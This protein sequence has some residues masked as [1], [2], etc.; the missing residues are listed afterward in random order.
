MKYHPNLSTA[1][2]DLAVSSIIDTVTTYNGKFI[3][4]IEGGIPTSIDG[5]YCIIADRDGKGW[6]MLDAVKE[7]GPKSKYVLAVGTCAAFGGV[8]KPSQYTGIKTVKEI[9]GGKTKNPVINLPSC[10]AHPNIFLGT[11]V[12]L[13]TKGLPKL[14]S[15]NR[16]QEYYYT[17]VHNNCPR[18]HTEMAGQVGAFGCYRSVGCN[19]PH[20]D[21]TC[22]LIKW[23]NGVNWCIDK[24]NMLCIG[25][26]SPNFPDGPFYQKG[27]GGMG[28]DGHS[29]GMGSSGNTETGNSSGMGMG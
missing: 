11:V 21:F 28:S 8:V 2:G 9:L 29:G 20:T 18:R 3:L 1:A 6:T 10:P 12:T 16:P 13:L 25:C 24:G 23:N 26:A 5:N 4:C 15:Y 7:L 14:D 22:P 27:M 17:T 19:G